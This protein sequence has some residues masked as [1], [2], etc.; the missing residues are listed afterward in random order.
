MDGATFQQIFWRVILPL[1]KPAVTTIALFSFM[2][3]YKDFMGPLVFLNTESKHTLELGL[4]AFQNLH[5]T[6][7]NYMMAAALIV[8]LPV[9]LI[10]FLGQRYFIEGI[11][12]T[13][14]KG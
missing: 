2:H 11:T 4:Q 3:S 12:L 10:F 13:G 14:I 7:Y 1:S 9:I 6:H 5:G 8:S